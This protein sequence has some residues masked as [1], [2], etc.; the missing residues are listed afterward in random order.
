MV[1]EHD[2]EVG[3][4]G[5]VDEINTNNRITYYVREI[6]YPKHQ[7]ANAGTC[8]ISTEG[9]SDMINWVCDKRSED[10]LGKIKLWGHSHHTM[11]TS[12]SGQDES[13]AID[14]MISRQSY[15]I[16]AICNKSGEMSLSFYDY[17][18]MLRFDDVP[19]V[20]EE[21]A[22]ESAAR[23]KIRALK[24]VNIPKP[25]MHPVITT[26]QYRGNN[27]QQSLFHNNALYKNNIVDYAGAV[28]GKTQG[29]ASKTDE[30]A[31]VSNVEMDSLL[32]MWENGAL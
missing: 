11:G 19:Y 13:Q 12:P 14:R 10:D 28:S 20:V 24:Q 9:E 22:E 1:E 23:E 7:L 29:P 8:E 15:V 16:R 4:F 17:D 2:E 30:K 25:V 3:F 18:R 6:F 27:A 31:I 5:I 26:G 21:N 32:S